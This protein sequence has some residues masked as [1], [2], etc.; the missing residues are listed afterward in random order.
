MLRNISEERHLSSGLMTESDVTP[1]FNLQRVW[2]CTRMTCTYIEMGVKKNYNVGTISL[3]TTCAVSLVPGRSGWFAQVFQFRLL[4][5]HY[6]TK[7]C[8]RMLQTFTAPNCCWARKELQLVT[9]PQTTNR[10]CHIS[11]YV[12]LYW[13]GSFS[14]LSWQC[15]CPQ[16][17]ALSKSSDKPTVNNLAIIKHQTHSQ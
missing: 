11:V 4:H 17:A 13:F 2:L 9:P 16:Q 6:C 7:S 12:Q 15:F 8:F 1:V 5:R 10:P 14:P 3:Q